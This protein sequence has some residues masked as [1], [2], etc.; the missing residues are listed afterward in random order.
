[1]REIRTSGLMSGDG[2]RSATAA[3]PRP[4]STRPRHMSAQAERGPNDA[5]ERSGLHD[6]DQMAFADRLAFID[7]DFLDDTRLGGQHGDFHLHRLKDHDL[8]FGLDPV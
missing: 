3:P 7:A 5:S 2:R 1:M 4:S 8:A 6:R